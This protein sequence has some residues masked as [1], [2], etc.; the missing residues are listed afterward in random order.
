MWLKLIGGILVLS[1]SAL[2]GA[3]LS[4]DIRRRPEELRELQGLLLIFENEMSYLSRPLPDVF[5]NICSAGRTP[6]TGFFRKTLGYLRS[7]QGISASEAWEGAIDAVFPQTG[8]NGEDKA[9]LMTFGKM[10]GS[11]DTEGHLKNIRLTAA[12]LGIQEKKAVEIRDKNEKI[13]KTLGI[14]GGIAIVIILL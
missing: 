6:V 4:E 9:I 1:A 5:Q 13:Y 2:I 8:L 10:L 12:R 14:L 3:L 7:C 11:A